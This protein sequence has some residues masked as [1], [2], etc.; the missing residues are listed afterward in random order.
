MIIDKIWFRK[1]SN[2]IFILYIY[3]NHQILIIKQINNL[4]TNNQTILVYDISWS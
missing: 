2:K 3:Y 1:F 4:N